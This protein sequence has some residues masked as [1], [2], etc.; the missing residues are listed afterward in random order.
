MADKTEKKV[1]Y[2]F[3]GDVSALQQ[4]VTS[5]IGILDQYQQKLNTLGETANAP[6]QQIAR[7]LQAPLKQIMNEVNQLQR[8]F[9]ELQNTKMF[10]N[11][12]EA[13]QMSTSLNE[14]QKQLTLFQNK[15]QVTASDVQTLSNALLR[16][17]SSFEATGPAINNLAQQG[18]DFENK[19]SGIRGKT[20]AMAEAIRNAF[21]KVAD[22]LN[23]V[24]AALK[25][26]EAKSIGT[27]NNTS[28]A[29][30]KLG[31]IF[32]QLSGDASAAGKAGSSA[33]NG[34]GALASSASKAGSASSSAAS[35]LGAFASG[36]SKAGAAG[37][38]VVVVIQAIIK[39]AKVAAK[40]LAITAKVLGTIFKTLSTPVIAY[41]TKSFTNSTSALRSF[42]EFLGGAQV[43][44]ALGNATQSAMA[45]IEN[46][47]LFTV[48]MGDSIDEANKFVDKMA[49]IYGMDPSNLYRY[50]GYFYQLSDAIGATSE[51]SK[52]M[53]LSLTK[54]A[55]DISSLFN[56]Q[57]ETVINDL[58]SG[59]QG[60]ARSV[61]K[62]G[63]DI[64]NTTLQQTALNYGFTENI[65]T[66]SEANRQALRYLTIMQQV[67][68]ATRQVTTSVDGSTKV[69][70]DFARN[71]ETPANQLRILKEQASQVARAFGNFFIPV[72]Q[73]VL[74]IVN[75]VLMALKTLLTF[76]ASIIGIDIAAFGG[77][78]S[79]AADD[80]AGGIGGIGDAADGAAKKLKNLI[81]PFDELTILSEPY[82]GGGGGV[83]GGIG[84]DLLDPGL[85]AAIEAMEAGLDEIRMKA[86]DVR[87]AILEALG[88]KLVDG[89]L[90]VIVGGFVD[91]L[92]KLWDKQD[93]RG[94]GERV[95]QFINQG[96]AWGVEHTDPNKYKTKFKLIVWSIAET[97]NGFLNELDWEGTGT[98]I[99]NGIN[100]A[101][102]VVNTW[103]KSFDFGNFARRIGDGINAAIHNI[104]WAL[105]GET[106]GNFIKSKILFA[107]NL[108]KTIDWYDLGVSIA[109]G[110]NAMVATIPWD[111]IGDLIIAGIDGLFALLEGFIDTFDFNA[112]CAKLGQLIQRIFENVDWHE[113][114]QILGELF[115]KLI[116]GIATFLDNYEPGTIGSALANLINGVIETINWTNFGKTFSDVIRA[117][118]REL[119]TFLGEL[120]WFEIGKSISEFVVSI[121]W[122]GLLEDVVVSVITILGTVVRSLLGNIVG[123]FTGIGDNIIGGFKDGILNGLKN[124]G[125]WLYDHLI[126]PVIRA[127][128][129][130]FG[131][132]SPST[133]FAAIGNWLIEG[134]YQGIKN[135]IAN[136]SA[137]LKNNVTDPVINAIKNFFGIHSPSTVLKE[138]GRFLTDGLFSGIATGM[139]NT[140]SWI[141]TNVTDQVIEAAKSGLGMTG[142]RSSTFQNM[143]ES[144]TDSLMS[145]LKTVDTKLNTWGSELST[146]VS[147]IFNGVSSMVGN[148]VSNIGSTMSSMVSNVQTSANSINSTL[149]NTATRVAQTSKN[150]QLS[151]TTNFKGMASGGVVKG[152]THAL[153]GEGAYDEAVIPLGNSPEL[154]EMINKI[155]DA[156]SINNNGNNNSQTPIEV[157]VYLD[158][159]EITSRQNRAAKMYGRSQLMI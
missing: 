123:I 69:M 38:V 61:R 14:L 54:A 25:S 147:N 95:A 90:E 28:Q 92:K 105:I 148:L 15:S 122:L 86:L 70:G 144:L 80:I 143:G 87:D 132:H 117:L 136:V 85:A 73:R 126:D 23:S 29:I 60:M 82:S 120:N 109:E 134:F 8:K 67:K 156:V 52:T 13:A 112:L 151:V 140:A 110:L 96:I 138:I 64:R 141:K 88:L 115:N 1:K 49:E 68:N 79:Q 18:K 48:A 50:A 32:R 34:L 153:I 21:S 98:I 118:G 11:I 97:L 62:Y 157:H 101:F 58:A 125:T 19:L 158:G 108:I 53:S 135:A 5:A 63:I 137:W 129:G 131:I 75:G 71:I 2:Q 104:D 47:N 16:A 89:E 6:T 24:S 17:K 93:F 57:V 65:A 150:A 74:Y 128:K 133:V 94:I 40:A 107:L 142:D 43:G 91:D 77:S 22:Y 9:K 41:I 100:L 72:M 66:T 42:V 127:V 81:A 84:S 119:I 154:Q 36:A 31:S 139:T 51:A 124:I 35:G 155:A 99:S 59:M 111:S 149:T 113:K 12:P 7:K 130:F 20:S 3:T 44:K 39:V 83:G 26:F 116:D 4:A 145:G 56:V 146:N 46:L 121:D 102:T 27:S 106:F 55:N 45:L 30:Q 76:L 78:V 33:A 103:L 10:Q 159:S 114:G 152:P 37:A